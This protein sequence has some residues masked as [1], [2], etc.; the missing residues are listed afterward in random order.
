MLLAVC[1]SAAMTC[2]VA[3]TYHAKQVI[4]CNE[5]VTLRAEPSTTAYAIDRVYRGDVVMAYKYNSKFNYCC[6]NGQ[7][8]YILSQYLSDKVGVYSEGTFRIANCESWVSLRSMPMS[9]SE[10]RA[11]IPLGTKL[12]AIYYAD[13]SYNPNAFAY[14]RYKGQYGWVM[15]RYIEPVNY[16]GA[17]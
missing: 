16:Y 3:E 14:V 2:A 7:F 5:Y 6:Y 1:L 4:K 11:K 9:S 13:G 17:Q 10:R 15:W 8:G 12:D